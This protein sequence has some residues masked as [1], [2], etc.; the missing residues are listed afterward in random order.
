[1]LG[2]IIGAAWLR[3]S[4]VVSLGG[5]SRVFTKALMV[6]SIIGPVLGEPSFL[7]AMSLVDSSGI[8]SAKQTQLIGAI[9]GVFQVKSEKL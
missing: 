1:M 8:P 7:Q 9:N 4:L 5:P 3:I 2:R 6:N